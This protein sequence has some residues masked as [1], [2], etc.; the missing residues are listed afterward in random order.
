M[1]QSTLD[2]VVQVAQLV[3]P[4]LIAFFVGHYHV[5]LN[6]AKPVDPNAP[7]PATPDVAHS[8]VLALLAG[9]GN[10]LPHVDPSKPVAPIGHGGLFQITSLLLQ[11]ILGNQ[12]T[13]PAQ[14]SLAVSQIVDATAPFSVASE[15]VAK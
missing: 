1:N 9:L 5:L 13:T 10:A 6:P 4:T 7:K 11:Q 15:P 2:V 8:G 12:N 14:K 3:I